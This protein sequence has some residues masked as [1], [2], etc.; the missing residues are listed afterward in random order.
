[1]ERMQFIL[2]IKEME[3][4]K[5][6]L[7]EKKQPSLIPKDMISFPRKETPYRQDTGLKE[8]TL[9]RKWKT[10]KTKKNSNSEEDFELESRRQLYS[11]ETRQIPD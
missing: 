7:Q 5:S 10:K 1:M 4:K 9:A 8:Q 6:S 2:T 11:L 3:K